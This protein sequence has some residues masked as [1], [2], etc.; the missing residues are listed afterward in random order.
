MQDRRDTHTAEVLIQQLHVAMN[1]LQGDQLVVLVL[2]GAAEIQTGVP[3][4][5]KHIG[6]HVG[7][8]DFIK[9]DL[10]INALINNSRYQRG[11]HFLHLSYLPM[12]YDYLLFINT[13]MTSSFPYNAKTLIR[14]D[15]Y[16][17]SCFF[18]HNL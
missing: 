12:L 6:E 2:D 4:T 9:K 13:I 16:N 11:L 1:D 17:N 7:K 5:S 8:A 3:V 14:H 10:R 18:V 15:S